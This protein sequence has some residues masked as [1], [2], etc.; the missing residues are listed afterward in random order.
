MASLPSALVS[1]FSYERSTSSAPPPPGQGFSLRDEI[2]GERVDFGRRWPDSQTYKQNLNPITLLG[3]TEAHMQ[4][5][6]VVFIKKK[7][8]IEMFVG[9]PKSFAQLNNIPF[10]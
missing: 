4:N 2:R 6:N 8:N 10:L 1:H 3:Q 9:E 5:V 7:V